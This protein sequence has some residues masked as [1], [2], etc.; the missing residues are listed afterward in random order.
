MP[1]RHNQ[2]RFLWFWRFKV[3]GLKIKLSERVY[4]CEVCETLLDR[5]LNAAINIER[6]G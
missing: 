3:R 2:N 4:H 1:L 5:D 6:E